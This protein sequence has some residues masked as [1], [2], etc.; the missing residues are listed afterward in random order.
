MPGATSS[1]SDGVTG[2]P[3]GDL[4]VL[5]ISLARRTVVVIGGSSGI[6]EQIAYQAVSHGAEVVVTGRD[7]T[8]LAAAAER[9][10]AQRTA[11][12]DAHDDDA[13]DAFFAGLGS[14]DHL[15]SMVGDSMSGG[16]LTTSPATMRHVLDSK[17][18]ANW[19]IA[20][21][22]AATLNPGGSITLTAGTG[23]R[24]HEV[25]ASYVANLA[26]GALVEGLA[27]ELAPDIRVN[28]VAP[29]FMDTPFWKDVPRPE[30]EAAKAAF[31]MHVPL[32]RLGTAP[33]V[34]SA[35]L[36]LITNGFIT[37]QVLAVDGGVMLQK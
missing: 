7:G 8:R 19:T 22:A 6:G 11:A 31:T 23:G 21:H 36:H 4:H 34:A 28:A 18:W 17:F 5:D 25:S 35:Y 9:V 2:L 27:I 10:G 30:L 3:Q 12:L 33:E 16:F 1:E 24:P 29:T 13:V 32:S 14:V 20:R 37:G 26:V 15:V